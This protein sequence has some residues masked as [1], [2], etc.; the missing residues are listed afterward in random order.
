MLKKIASSLVTASTVCAAGSFYTH[1]KRFQEEPVKFN[2][3]HYGP[4]GPNARFLKSDAINFFA[5]GACG[6]GGRFEDTAVRDIAR[7]TVPL[8]NV[9]KKYN[10]G[11]GDTIV[12]VGAGTG[13]FLSIFSDLV[14][15]TGTVKAIDIIP[16]FVY[17]MEMRVKREGIKNV[18]VT[19]C[20]PKSTR[21]EKNIA[22][23]AFICDVYHHFEY[24]ITFM[25]SLHDTLKEN[26]IVVLVD[27][28][29]DPAKLKTR[30]PKW[31]LAHLRAG[32]EVFLEEIESA[33]FE[34]IEDI[35]LEELTDNYCMVFTKK[36]S[37]QNTK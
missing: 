24:P 29:R 37:S 10:I 11:K 8:A 18:D 36:M 28:H 14:G 27:F 13:L 23:A 31:A 1:A 17:H 21:L 35:Y 7:A 33:G 34:L 4:L 25:R 5:G 19:R 20:T 12:D 2:E 9:L 22:D 26:A 6:G 30:D 3:D 16:K 15:E 32:Q